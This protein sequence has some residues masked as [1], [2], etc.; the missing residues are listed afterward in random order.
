VL[1]SSPISRVVPLRVIAGLLFGVVITLV[2]VVFLPEG[3]EDPQKPHNVP[4]ALVGPPPAVAQLAAVLQRRGAFRAVATPTEASAKHLVDSR[5]AD[6]IINLETRQLQTAQAASI[7]VPIAPVVQQFLSASPRR[8]HLATSDIKPLPRGDSAGLGL[9]FT[10]FAFVF[11]GIPAGVVLALTMR[12]HRPASVADAGAWAALI[13]A[14]SILQ[15]LLVA[16]LAEATLGYERHQFLI[17]WEWGALVTAASMGSTAAAI[18]VFGLPA[19]LLDP[20]RH[21]TLRRSRGAAAKP[22]EL[23]VRAL[24]GARPLRPDGRRRQC[25][26]QRDLLPPSVAGPE[27]AGAGG[28]DSGS[29]VGSGR[30]RLARPAAGGARHPS[31]GQRCFA[32]AV[33]ARIV[34]E[35]HQDPKAPRLQDLQSGV[36]VLDGRMRY[37]APFMVSRN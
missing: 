35:V 21:R 1:N 19:A 7:T 26:T 16:V 18:A 11:G 33:R 28:V 8:L 6:A 4:V 15:S 12:N 30:C 23:R 5:K 25:D 34:T 22:L 24:Q 2:W 13:A 20:Y 37:Y 31:A 3:S 17:I 10:T 27:G 29:A 14:Y 9:F 32:R 36:G